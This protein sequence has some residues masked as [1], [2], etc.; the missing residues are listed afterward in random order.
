MRLNQVTVGSTDLDR[1]EWF[2]RLLGLQLIVKTADYLRFE[3][4]SGGSTFSVARVGEVPAAEQ[5]TIYFEV[6][7]VDENYQRLR[8][9]IEFTQAPA[10]MPWLWREAR[11]RDPDGHRLCL[12]HGGAA[13]RDPPWRLPP[14]DLP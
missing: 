14:E 9:S 12:F 11:L 4:P 6:D 5:V 13:R 7:D 1:A 3:C 8:A 10:D 2:Y